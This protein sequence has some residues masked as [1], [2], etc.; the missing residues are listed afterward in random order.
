MA[1]PTAARITGIETASDRARRARTQVLAAQYN[2]TVDE[3]AEMIDAEAEV[4]ASAIKDLVDAYGGRVIPYT[5]RYAQDSTAL[6]YLLGG[7][8]H[9]VRE[10]GE[11]T[12]SAMA[13]M[14][15]DALAFAVR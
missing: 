11:I 3:A 12:G 1:F 10:H 13:Q 14:V 2:V 15:R 6:F 8:E 9:Y 5:Q 4:A 7:I